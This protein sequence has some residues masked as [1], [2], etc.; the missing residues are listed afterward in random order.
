MNEKHVKN[1]RRL[2]LYI[3]MEVLVIFF[4]QIFTSTE[5]IVVHTE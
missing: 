5:M 1:R 3:L 4:S 2:Y